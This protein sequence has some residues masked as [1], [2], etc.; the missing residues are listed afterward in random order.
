MFLGEGICC[1]WHVS[2]LP[3]KR[4]VASR[5]DPE[6]LKRSLADSDLHKPRAWPL[7]GQ[8]NGAGS[9]ARIPTWRRTSR[10]ATGTSTALRWTSRRR[11]VA[12]VVKTSMGSHSGVGEFTHFRTYFSGDW[13]VHWGL[14][15]VLTHGR[16]KFAAQNLVWQRRLTL[17][18]RLMSRGSGSAWIWQSESAFVHSKQN[19]IPLVSVNGDLYAQTTG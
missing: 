16:V 8:G 3:D 10:A 9:R 11:R 4:C 12:V 5:A 14:T 17:L 1:L 6:G 19:R 7:W 15:G 13:D 2:V 18:D